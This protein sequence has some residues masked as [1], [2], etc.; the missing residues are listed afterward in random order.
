MTAPRT[1]QADV[2]IVG[3]GMVGSTIACGLAEAGIS[4]MLVERHPTPV[5]RNGIELRVSAISHASQRIYRR[6]GVWETMRAERVS[7]Y[8][9]MQV[10]ENGSQIRF[11]AAELGE[12]DLGHIVENDVMVRA[13]RQRLSQLSAVEL[14]CPATPTSLDL[15]DR[16]P[17]LRLA[18]GGDLSAELIIAADGANSHLRQWAGIAL[19]AASYDQQAVVATFECANGNQETAWQRFLPTGPLA[20]LPI[21]QAH[22]SIVWS[23]TPG[24]AEEYLDMDPADFARA[25]TEASEER[26]GELTL[27]GERGAFPLRHQHAQRY[28]LPGLALAGDAA[29]QVHPLAGQGVN[30]GLLDAAELIDVLARAKADGRALG[31]LTTL[32]AYERHRRGENALMQNAFTGFKQL[33][34]ND[35]A[36]LRGLR[37]FG[38][39]LANR[40]GPLKHW[41]ARTAMGETGPMPPLA[42]R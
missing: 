26:L 28:V 27:V 37:R 42:A 24:H 8:Q 18:D 17:S 36:P 20:L 4:S 7:P 29:H 22:C 41:F 38:L 15:S 23:T 12:A 5:R 9:T 32:R 25:V 35:I 33:F 30:L 21:G 2:I 3:G 6:L 13:L 34:S 40:S 14:V 10:W 11:D 1:R 19:D 39:D 31:A 16:R